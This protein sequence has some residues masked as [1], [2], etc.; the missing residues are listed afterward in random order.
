M[1][2]GDIL[3]QPTPSPYDKFNDGFSVKQLINFSHL[4]APETCD[5]PSPTF[6][7]TDTADASA[8]V[9]A[10]APDGTVA[11]LEA[12]QPS[13]LVLP[14]F[15]SAFISAKFKRGIAKK[16]HVFCNT[17]VKES[18]IS[19]SLA[20]GIG[21]KPMVADSDMVGAYISFSKRGARKRIE[22]K[23]FPDSDATPASEPVILNLGSQN[24][25]RL[26]ALIDVRRGTCPGSRT[27]KSIPKSQVVD[28]D[29]TPNR[30]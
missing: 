27:K 28:A 6:P 9:S 7:M 25:K 3:T 1:N 19:R 15:A 23:V 10:T 5:T 13:T 29:A 30:G 20:N 26:H 24:L 11:T 18:G 8:V 17:A 16:L 14:L 2:Y 21:L 12:C 22:F 4:S